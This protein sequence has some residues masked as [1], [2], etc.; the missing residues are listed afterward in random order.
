[1]AARLA[2]LPTLAARAGV[3]LLLAAALQACGS[4]SAAG[5][6]AAREA[7]ELAHQS[8]A[9]CVA[10]VMH[11]SAQI[12][13]RVYH[14][15]VSSERTG[16]AFRF[17]ARSGA[18]RAAA[19]HGDPAAARAAAQA[20]VAG[21]RLTNLSV[22]RPNGGLLA[23]V[24]PAA[25]APLRGTITGAGGAVVGSFVTSVWAD[26]GIVAE[27]SGIAQVFTVVRAQG[28]NVAGSFPLPPG[29]L[30]AKGSLRV[31]GV[32]YSY[33]SISGERYPSGP[34]RIYLF[35]PTSSI[36]PLCGS[37]ARE[38]VKHTLERVANA[39]YA[40]EGGSRAQ[41][42]VR[43]VQR[44]A[45]FRRAAARRDPEA[46]RLAISNL[47]T[48]H[49]VRL[50]V[51]AGGRLLADVGGPYVLAPVQ[52]VLRDGGRR[53]ADFELAIQDDEGYLRLLRRL[54]GINVLM[55][56]G[57]RLV[58]NSLGPSPGSVPPSG[59]YRYRGRSFNVFTVHAQAFPSGPLEIR[60]L[61]PIPYS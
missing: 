58:K 40:G 41:T 3:G 50:R 54:A 20:L 37:N 36:A 23:D 33:T 28:R 38:T 52:A 57:P 51:N 35:R 49:I 15:G 14:Q 6:D 2:T 22:L 59:L 5:D 18:L 26:D 1:M 55:Y 48:E 31:K 61:I 7:R 4:G 43:R 53:I 21:G 34:V 30:P 29:Q 10:T 17:I 24:G 44:D 12:A 47:L 45:A 32:E 42:Q 46:T 9:G 27:T 16:V 11:T 8:R 60:A 19:E 25:V 13:K 39:I 56:M